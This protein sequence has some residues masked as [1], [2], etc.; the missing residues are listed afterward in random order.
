VLCFTGN[1]FR[2]ASRNGLHSAD[3][4]CVCWFRYLSVT[5]FRKVAS[6]I[7][8]NNALHVVVLRRCCGCSVYTGEI[9]CDDEYLTRKELTMAYLKTRRFH[10]PRG[11]RRGSMAACFLALR[12]QIPPWAWM[13]L[14]CECCVVSGRRLCVGLIPRTE[15]PYRVWCVWVWSRNLIDEA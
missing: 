11:L 13:Y 7:V 1:I 10:W 5:L 4:G 3:K 2:F 12:V 8:S 15:E 14:S 6:D 9:R